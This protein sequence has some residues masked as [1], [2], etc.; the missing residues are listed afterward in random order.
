MPTPR[1]PTNGSID[2]ALPRQKRETMSG[3][4][5]S[6]N[7]LKAV[8]ALLAFIGVVIA[9]VVAMAAA[10]AGKADTADL[11]RVKDVVHEIDVRQRVMQNDQATMKENQQMFIRAIRPDLPVKD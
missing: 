9:S 2:L 4:R 11:N 6:W 8:V 7:A 5:I 3:L 10:F 1:K